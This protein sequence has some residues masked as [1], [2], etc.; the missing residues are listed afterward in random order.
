M[1]EDLHEDPAVL[2]MAQELGV[3]PETI[4]GYC[5]KF[6]G[7]VSRQTGDGCLVG[8]SL[9]S[10]GNVISL[11]GFP[12]LLVQAGWLEY[13]DSGQK[14]ITRIP[15]FERHLSEGAKARALA[16]EKK[17]KQRAEMSLKNG[18]KCPGETGTRREETRG[19]PIVKTFMG[20]RKAN[21]VFHVTRG[22]NRSP[23]SPI[24]LGE[25]KGEEPLDVSALDWEHVAAMAEAVG[26]RIAPATEDDRRAWLRFAVLAETS[27]G[28]AWLVDAAE[29]VV[30]AKETR[31]TR[32]AHFVGVLKSKALDQ[33]EVDGETFT[34]MLRRIEIPA[35]VWKSDVLGGLK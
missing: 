31:K 29:A 6:W 34:A 9:V 16:A 26:K 13:D 27:F 23:Q 17:R 30:A 11:P 18:D 4:V 5:H 1:R 10:L 8:P 2:W 25:G 19:D 24:N 32:Q 12:E 20:D 21:G 28:E 33:H 7:L 35:S 22:E 14:P 3:R 15:K